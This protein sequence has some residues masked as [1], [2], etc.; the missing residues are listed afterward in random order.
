MLKR[1][2]E[3]DVKKLVERIREEYSL[4]V[5]RYKDGNLRLKEENTELR[6]RL[7][8]LEGE[9]ENV[10][11]ALV[12]AVSEGDRIKRD[13]ELEAENRNRELML[14][15]EKCRLLSDRLLKKYPDEE[16]CAEFAAFTDSLRE[17]LGMEE[18]PTEF[19]MEEVLAPKQPLDLEKL[20]R[21]LGVMGDDDVE[22][23]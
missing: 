20:C 15:A 11:Q 17:N 12:H 10:S 7:S 8:V 13:G 22:T 1:Y 18:E 19:D 4:V 9:R 5:E 14:L 3:K 23:E 21:D 6:A 16:D 2:K